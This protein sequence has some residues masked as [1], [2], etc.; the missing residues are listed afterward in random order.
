MAAIKYLVNLDL[1]KNQLLNAVIQNLGTQPGSPNEGQIFWH[2]GDKKAYVYD[3][4]FATNNGWRELGTDDQVASEVPFTPASSNTRITSTDVQDALEKVEVYTTE[5]PT[6]TNSTNVGGITDTRT[7]S[8]FKD[9]PISEIL[10]DLLFP[11]IPATFTASTLGVSGYNSNALEVGEEYSFNADFTFTPG[12]ITN[13][14]GTSA[15]PV[16]G[17]AS[18]FTV[19]KPDAV[20]I[21]VS[22]SLNTGTISNVSY[23]PTT[24][25]T[26]TWSF[27]ATHA[28]SSTTYTDNKGSSAVTVG[29]IETAKGLTSISNSGFSKNVYFPFITGMSAN[30]T[31]SA[32][33]GFYNNGDLGKLIQGKGTKSVALNA[34]DAY[35]YFGYPK[36][37]GALTSI[38][39]GNGFEILNTFT[40]YDFEVSSNGLDVNWAEDYYVYRT[41]SLTTVVTA[42]GA[43]VFKF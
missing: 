30:N 24:S 34:S 4:T 16:S 43:Y 33:T 8:D 7:V 39:D 32:G 23:T 17:T 10:D 21:S 31:V 41:T 9:K 18:E 2:T 22:T 14:T 37:H 12:T 42:D 40:Q 19:T 38:K 28:A 15:G 29:T 13:G 26:K 11:T 3:S 1:S 25:G 36:S 35:V 20:D 6:T 5:L 27:S